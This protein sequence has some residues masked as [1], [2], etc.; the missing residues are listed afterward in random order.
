VS[1]GDKANEYEVFVWDVQS[2]NPSEPRFRCEWKNTE[3]YAVCCFVRIK[4][5][6]RCE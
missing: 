4:Q 5:K 1:E 6:R 2:N 3:N